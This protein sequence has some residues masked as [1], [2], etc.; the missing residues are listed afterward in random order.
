MSKKRTFGRVTASILISFL[1]ILNSCQKDDPPAPLAVASFDYD[2]TT[3]IIGQAPLNV[4]F[5]NNSENGVSYSWDFGDGTSSTEEAPLH[6]YAGGGTYTV[7]LIAT[8]VDGN[9]SI[10][11]AT[12][13][14][15]SPLVGTWVLDS[16][17]VSTIDTFDTAGAF[18][19]GVSE[20]GA[21]CP[22]GGFGSTQW[23][24]WDGSSWT[25]VY[26][27][28]EPYGFSTFWSNI[29]FAG[30]YFGR[31][32]FFENEFT[33]NVDE[34]YE[35]DL[36]GDLRLPDFIVAAEGDY[37][38]S[39]NWTNNDGADINAWKSNTEHTY[40]I[41]ESTVFENHGELTLSGEGAF[42]GVYFA[43]VTGTG[44]YKVP[45]SEYKFVISSVSSDQLIVFGFSADLV[46]A[47]DFMVLKFKKL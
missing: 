10:D 16:T 41:T 47:S 13:E 4:Q 31:T 9:T 14:L 22:G 11:E 39:E 7:K 32:D 21:V 15:A 43:G 24:A 17:A 8:N 40:S 23:E 1:L 12:I 42:L 5:V 28:A 36:K 26:N 37:D 38:E 20:T 2:A 30:S 18:E 44:T 35:V 27:D 45:Q 33:F 19:I 3:D 25:H 34:S 6:V 46:C 29:I